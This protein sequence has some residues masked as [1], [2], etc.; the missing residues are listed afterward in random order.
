MK[1]SDVQVRKFDV[2]KWEEIS[3]IP[4]QYEK[5]EREITAEEVEAIQRYLRSQQKDDRTIW[6]KIKAFFPGGHKD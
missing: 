1:R 5:V 2:A 4:Q 3:F 6:Q